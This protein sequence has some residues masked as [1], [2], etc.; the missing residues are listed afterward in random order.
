MVNIL[1]W[2]GLSQL[3]KLNYQLY[4]SR[5]FSKCPYYSPKKRPII[6]AHTQK[7][8][9][10]YY[11]ATSMMSLQVC[12]PGGRSAVDHR[13]NLLKAKTLALQLL[14][15]STGSTVA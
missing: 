10:D 7:Y 13:K 1:C 4:Y 3:Y 11:I 9:S 14:W 5:L 8:F 6:P 15:Y 12:S 2:V